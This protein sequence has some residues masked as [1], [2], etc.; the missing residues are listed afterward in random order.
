MVQVDPHGDRQ[1]EDQ[2]E[3]GTTVLAEIAVQLVGVFND[4]H[5]DEGDAAR[6][7]VDQLS[8]LDEDLI[9]VKAQEV[10]LSLL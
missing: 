6:Q 10:N 8:A 3:A 4:V 2:V 7:R 9:Q 1:A 5:G